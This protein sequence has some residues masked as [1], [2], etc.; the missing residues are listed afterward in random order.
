M[1]EL[2]GI[3]E[4]FV[5]I[6]GGSEDARFLLESA[7]QNTP[8]KI[9][10]ALAALPAVHVQI[11]PHQEFAKREEGE[12]DGV[13]TDSPPVSRAHGG[14]DAP[15]V[16]GRKPFVSLGEVRQRQAEVGRQERAERE[17]R[18]QVLVPEDKSEPAAGAVALQIDG[19]EDQRSE[20]LDAGRIALVPAQEPQ[21]EEE[22]AD[23]LL[24]LEGLGVPV[25]GQER[26]LE[27]LGR[28]PR[29]Q[30]PVAVPARDSRARGHFLGGQEDRLLILVARLP[31]S[32][33]LGLR[34]LEGHAAALD[35]ENPED[36]VGDF[37]LDGNLL[38]PGLPDRR[39][40]ELVAFS[41]IEE[42]IPE[43]GERGFHAVS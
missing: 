12:L 20:P 5:E 39:A 1:A 13:R 2:P 4:P 6:L 14:V 10:P 41:D 19:K 32:P 40:D 27:P 15:E 11:L 37:V 26:L 33:A 42:L 3:G 7:D 17:V 36:L 30:L 25:E 23:A 9:T 43:A 29:L 34:R 21:G 18:L 35:G 22:D 16:L 24:L 28:E 31:R 38:G 8:Q